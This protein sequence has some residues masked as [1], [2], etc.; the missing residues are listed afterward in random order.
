[1]IGYMF[2][3]TSIYYILILIGAVVAIYANA[4]EEQ[5]VTILIFGIIILMFGVFKIQST[6][7]SKKDK[8]SFVKTEPIDEEE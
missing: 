2:K 7:P 1:M 8:E 6:I 5:N 4:T 3:N